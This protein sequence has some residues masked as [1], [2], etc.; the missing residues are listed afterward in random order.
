MADSISIL[1]LPSSIPT[2][3]VKLNG[4]NYMFW[5][6]IMSPLLETY[7]LLSYAEG[8]VPEPSK[9]VQG[10]DGSDL[11]NPEHQKW[12]S[13]DKFALTCI[14]LAVTEE[15]GVTILSAKTSH[16]AWRSLETAF[17]SHT[18]VQEDLLEQQWRN[19][20]KG[21]SMLGFINEVKKKAFNFAQIGK[22]K[23][24]AEVNRRIYTGLG[25]E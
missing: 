11:Q 23:T 3:Q 2:V 25:P 24:Q 10:P 13:R 8:R 12:V 20:R 19:L 18:A 9:T 16:K 22:P 5:K 14:M 1:N 7:G 17:L 4:R 21:S 15:I 6:G